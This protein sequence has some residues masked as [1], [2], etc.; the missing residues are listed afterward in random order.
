MPKYAD[1]PIDQLESHPEF[2]QFGNMLAAGLNFV[3]NNAGDVKLLRTLL[4][5]KSTKSFFAADV[6]IRLQLEVQ[7]VIQYA[8]YGGCVV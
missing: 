6:P 3:L 8:L 7:Y 4:G 5:G 1:V 2:V